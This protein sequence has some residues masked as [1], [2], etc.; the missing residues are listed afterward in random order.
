MN[1]LI[2]FLICSASMALLA[3]GASLTIDAAIHLG[4]SARGS[5]A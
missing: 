4:E 3:A 1:K 2:A 5:M